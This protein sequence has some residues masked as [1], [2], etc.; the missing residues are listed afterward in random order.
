MEIV[1]LPIEKLNAAPYNPRID[2]K[3]GDKEY[4]KLKKSILTFGYIDPIIVNKRGYVVVG[5]HQRLKILQATGNKTVEVSLV[6]LPRDQEK[7][8]NIALN[9]TGGGWDIPKLQ[10]LLAELQETGMDIEITGYDDLEIEELMRVALADEEANSPKKQAVEDD[11]DAEEEAAKI[12]N[13][14]SK[15]GDIWLLGRHRL[16]CGDATKAEDVQRLVD[17]KLCNMVFTDPP[18]NVSYVGKTAD[19]LKI[20]N[21]SMADGDFYKFLL[22]AYQNMLEAVEPGGAIYVCHADT[23]GL[24]FRKAMVD[25]GWLL[26]QCLVWIKNSMVLGRQDYHWQHEPILYGWR[27]GAAH[28]WNSDRKQTTVWPFDRPSRSS[29]HPTMKP[30]AIPVNAIQNSSKAGDIVLDLFGGSGSTLI[31]AEQTGRVCYT[32]EIDPVY[33]D[34]IVSRYIAFTDSYKRVFLLRNGEKK[35]YMDVAGEMAS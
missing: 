19:S 9:K 14:V 21:D 35:A 3:P 27:P 5:G 28:V 33:A 11:F 7:A 20:Q 15:P 34:V 1:K 2:L 13:P 12:K 25:A 32:S 31:A 17:G 29:D 8:L 22:K 4:E 10:D 30:V 26:K 18:Y 6:D 16:L 24:N 23:E